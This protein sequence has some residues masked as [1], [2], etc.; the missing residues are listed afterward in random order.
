MPTCAQ[1]ACGKQSE[2]TLRSA[3]YYCMYPNY[4]PGWWAFPE[5]VTLKLQWCPQAQHC[6]HP[7]PLASPVAH[8]PLGRWR[9][10]LER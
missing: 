5:P 3:Y 1:C 7:P 10:L 9:S 4:P 8:F 6:M 2:R